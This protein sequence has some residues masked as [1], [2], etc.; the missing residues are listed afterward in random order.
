MEFTPEQLAAQSAADD[1][2]AVVMLNLVAYRATAADGSG[3]GLD[4]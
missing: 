1:G 3:S 4:A 2:S